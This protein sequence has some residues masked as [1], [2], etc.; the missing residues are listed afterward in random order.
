MNSWLSELWQ[1]LRF[2]VNRQLPKPFQN[3]QILENSALPFQPN[4]FTHLE[5]SVRQGFW[6]AEF[7]SGASTGA[8]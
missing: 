6:K 5:C 3:L 2:F 4:R 1:R 8:C 7:S